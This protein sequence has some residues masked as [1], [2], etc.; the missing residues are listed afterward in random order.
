MRTVTL[1][2][3]DG[4]N[5]QAILRLRAAPAQMHLVADVGTSLADVGAD[6]TMTAYAVYDGSQLGLARPEQPPV[7]FAVTEVTAGIGFILRVMV[8]V[9]HQG[10]GYGRS[11]MTALVRRLARLPDVELIATS[12]REDNAAM[13]HLCAQLGF[14]PWATPF[15]P[16]A[17]EVY[18]R[19]GTPDDD[20]HLPP[21]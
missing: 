18:L 11:L 6:P 13:A 7:G 21:T 4:D 8:D 17:G 20:L 15:Q 19:F 9:D 5:R 3:V 14:Q 1:R 10:Q 16:P 2:P 12:H